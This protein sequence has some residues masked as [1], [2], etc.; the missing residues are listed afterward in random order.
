MRKAP[1]RHS[2]RRTVLASSG[3][4]STPLAT[5]SSPF[6]AASSWWP[7]AS[8]WPWSDTTSP[9]RSRPQF[10]SRRAWSPLL[11]V[12]ALFRW[13]IHARS[14][15]LTLLMGFL[16]I[17]TTFVGLHPTPVVQLAALVV[18]L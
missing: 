18:I 6:S 14:V 1:K 12:L 2:I 17:L 16:A 4:R 13:L 10:F 5:R 11:A 3:L 9:P 15:A 8:S 7:P